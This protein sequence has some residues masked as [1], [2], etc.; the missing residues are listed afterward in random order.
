MRREIWRA[1]RRVR[2]VSVWRVTPTSRETI[3]MHECGL[4]SVALLLCWSPGGAYVRQAC[5][6]MG[7]VHWVGAASWVVRALDFFVCVGCDRRIK[8]WM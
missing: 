2:V 1:G 7:R 6:C 8:C 5:W 4:S 3:Y